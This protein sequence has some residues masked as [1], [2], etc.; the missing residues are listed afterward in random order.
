MLDLAD[1]SRY[2]WVM[3]IRGIFA[4]IFGLIALFA[5][6]LALTTLVLMFG[7]YALIDGIGSIGY[8]LM[9]RQRQR[10]WLGLI[11]GIISVLAGLVAF[12]LPILTGLTLLLVIGFWAI[13]I[14]IAQIVAAIQL[15]KEIEGEFWLGLAGLMAILFGGYI[16]IAPAG[17]A[18]ALAWLIGLFAILYGGALI[19]LSLRL[20]RIGR[21]IR[22]R[23]TPTGERL[24]SDDVQTG[25]QTGA[26]QSRQSPLTGPT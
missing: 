2:W 5:P 6:A 4:V 3:L 8:A 25:A 24:P 9:N 26:Q 18:L 14:G 15:R 19:A 11:T 22:E 12:L 16:I 17:G 23:P 21:S 7:I 1:V 20:R 10:W 13:F